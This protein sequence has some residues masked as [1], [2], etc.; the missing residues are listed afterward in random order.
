MIQANQGPVIIR[1][2]RFEENI[3]TLGGAL[4]I[5]APDFETNAGSNATNSV[6]YIYI[7]DNEFIKNMAYFAGNAYYITHAIDAVKDFQ[8]YKYMCGA[9]VHV[10]NNHFEGNMGLKRH[11]GGASVH[12]C[13][14]LDN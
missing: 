10:A 3:G 2:N 4:H 13:L 11:N 7:E 8:D 9:G 6:P 14:K 5:Y 12:R 1:K